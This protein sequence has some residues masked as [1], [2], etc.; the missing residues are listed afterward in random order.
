MGILDRAVSQQKSV[1]LKQKTKK[2]MAA[3]EKCQECEELLRNTTPVRSFHLL[4]VL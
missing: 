3:L 4:V 2:E 1:M